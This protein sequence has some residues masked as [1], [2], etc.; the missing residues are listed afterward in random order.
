MTR[1]RGP[2]IHRTGVV[3]VTSVAHDADPETCVTPTPPSIRHAM[4]ER[5]DPGQHCKGIEHRNRGQLL[6]PYSLKTTRPPASNPE[7]LE[8]AGA[9]HT[10]PRAANASSV[11]KSG[12]LVV[13]APRELPFPP[14][15][16]QYRPDPPD[17]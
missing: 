16:S 6:A 3:G 15:A 17:W 9:G 14:A 8:H 12:D 1:L 10:M 7:L 2:S 4:R 13:S 11:L 5:K